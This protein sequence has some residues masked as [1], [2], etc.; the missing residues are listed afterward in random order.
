MMILEYIGAVQRISLG[1]YEITPGYQVI[2]QRLEQPMGSPGTCRP[3]TGPFGERRV[4]ILTDIRARS[5]DCPWKKTQFLYFVG[6]PYIPHVSF[7]ALCSLSTSG[8]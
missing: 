8:K 4:V 2:L 5:S 1:L 3:A 6:F 7:V